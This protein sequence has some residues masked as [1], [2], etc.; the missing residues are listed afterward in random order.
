MDLYHWAGYRP[1]NL[2]FWRSGS[3]DWYQ[4]H[5]KLNFKK[6]KPTVMPTKWSSRWNVHNRSTH[7]N[8]VIPRLAVILSVA[9]LPFFGPL[10]RFFVPLHGSEC[11]KVRKTINLMFCDN[12]DSGRLVLVSD[13]YFFHPSLT[14]TFNYDWKDRWDNMMV[15]VIMER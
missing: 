12:A 3:Q 4:F 14:I 2:T 11:T 13:L 1:A 15:P 7:T 6:N 5:L 10:S 8:S 9:F